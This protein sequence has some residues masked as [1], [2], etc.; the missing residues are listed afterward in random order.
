MVL[1]YS[2]SQEHVI[3]LVFLTRP[4]CFYCINSMSLNVFSVLLSLSR[5]RITFSSK[6][7]SSDSIFTSLH[8]SSNLIFVQSKKIL[9][10]EDQIF[11]V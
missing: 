3:K 5:Y 2:E 9:A 7:L 1:M 6:S 11:F 8:Q 10:I 4:T